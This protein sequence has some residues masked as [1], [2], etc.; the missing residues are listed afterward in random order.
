MLILVSHVFT[1]QEIAGANLTRR[2]SKSSSF[3]H[4]SGDPALFYPITYYLLIED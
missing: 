4:T 2:P 3:E 1:R